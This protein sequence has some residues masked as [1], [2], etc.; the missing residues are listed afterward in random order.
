MYELFNHH[1]VATSNR[2]R[3]ARVPFLKP[4]TV[5]AADGKTLSTQTIDISDG[6]VG[7]TCRVSFRVG[8][9]VVVAFR[10]TDAKLGVCE[11]RVAG[12]V[13]NFQADFEVNRVGVEFEEPLHPSKFPILARAVNRL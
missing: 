13:V 12:R 4:V 7:F 8:E 9:P 10:L 3:Y 5:T 2:R 6:G 11:E 1:D